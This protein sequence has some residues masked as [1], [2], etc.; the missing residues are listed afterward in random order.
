M[1]DAFVAFLQGESS[2][3][4]DLAEIAH[5]SK[6][7]V[8]RWVRQGKL[9]TTNEEHRLVAHYD[10]NHE[11]VRQQSEKYWNKPKAA[12]VPKEIKRYGRWHE[13]LDELT[14]LLKVSYSAPAEIKK[15]QFRLDHL[16]ANF[17]NFHKVNIRKLRQVLYSGVQPN[18]RLIIDDLKRGWY[19]ELAY[20][21]PLKASTLG[22]TFKDIEQNKQIATERFAFPS[23][24]ITI[25]YYS[26]YFFLRSITLQKQSNLRLQEHSATISSFKNN[27]LGPL[28]RVVWKPPLTFGTHQR[29]DSRNPNFSSDR[30]PISKTHTARIHDHRNVR[31]F[32]FVNTYSERSGVEPEKE[33]SHTCI[34][35]WTTCTILGFG[36]TILKSTTC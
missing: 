11:F 13:L 8:Y 23:W 27:V 20:S 35:F 32:S 28:S 10:D 36:R 29:P 21:L 15:K 22:L 6:S 25:A 7:T 19:N 34:Q 3:I 12:F 5:V 24:R 18:K 16:F 33:E 31:P 14:W 30:F 2:T 26:A 1:S 17:L 4:S 9:K